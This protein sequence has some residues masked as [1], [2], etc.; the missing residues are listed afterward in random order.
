MLNLP[1]HPSLALLPTHSVSSLSHPTEHHHA[2]VQ[3][4]TPTP[5]PA[6]RTGWLQRC[7][8]AFAR[9]PDA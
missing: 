3:A 5:A 4:A 7:L 6:V 9:T 8:R 2:E 1:L